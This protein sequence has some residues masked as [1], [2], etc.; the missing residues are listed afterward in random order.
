MSVR[1]KLLRKIAAK[2]RPITTLISLACLYI[3]LTLSSFGN[4]AGVEE[5]TIQS[6][7]TPPFILADDI[8]GPTLDLPSAFTKLGLPSYQLEVAAGRGSI[9]YT[10]VESKRGDSRE[11]LVYAFITSENELSEATPGSAVGLTLAKSLLRVQWLSK[12]IYILFVPS[13]LRNFSSGIRAWL[14]D[15]FRSSSPSL[16]AEKPMIRGAFVMDLAGGQGGIPIMEVEGING[17]F[18]NADVAHLFLEVAEELGF[19]VTTRL[20]YESI[21]YSALNGGVHAPHTPFLDYG[22]P[23]ITLSRSRTAGETTVKGPSVGHTARAV[24][25]HLRALSAIHHQLHHST[26]FYFYGGRRL[27]IAFGILLP[28]LVG[29]ISPLFVGVVSLTANHEPVWMNSLVIGHIFLAIFVVGGGLLFSIVRNTGMIGGADVCTDPIRG[30]NKALDSSLAVAGVL[31][32]M[33]M[34]FSRWLNKRCEIWDYPACLKTAAQKLYSLILTVLIL[35]H[36]SLA[37]V[38]SIFVIPLLAMV[39]PLRLRKGEIGRTIV[40]ILVLVICA[41]GVVS[42]LTGTWMFPVSRASFADAML[43]VSQFA[44]GLPKSVYPI[45]HFIDFLRNWAAGDI[46]IRRKLS[47]L[48][49]EFVCHQGLA[50][51]GLCMV[52][53]PALLVALEVAVGFGRTKSVNVE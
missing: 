1:D 41:F 9:D 28:T 19:P 47:T 14:D 43:S 35:M 32:V 44:R 26:H 20:V 53:F 51:P 48:A 45:N 23:A 21:V 31:A 24:G 17:A 39:S 29:F 42:V 15:F 8:T 38:S 3:L 25:K 6:G 33:H 7:G 37:A 5:D 12:D 2:A 13:S 50:L 49:Q 46:S 18:P 34:A 10:V 27:E 36:W 4:R 40:S 52:I 11:A 16:S 22:I 30:S